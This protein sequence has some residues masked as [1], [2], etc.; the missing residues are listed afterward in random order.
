MQR[1]LLG[2]A[3]LLLRKP[4]LRAR[5]LHEIFGV[6]LIHDREIR[7]E[8]GRLSKAA[9]ETVRCG[10][11]GA[12]VHGAAGAAHEAFGAAEHFLGGP[13]REGQEKNP[14]GADSILEQVCDAIHER[15]RFSRARARDDQQR[16]VCVRSR[17]SFR[18]VEIRGEIGR[19]PGLDF[20]DA[21]RV[22]ARVVMHE[23]RI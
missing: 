11:K 14:L 6:G 19:A 5:E 22:D 13:P 18:R 15:A 4:E 9:E 10:V 20:A 23:I 12:A 3:L 7:R 17:L 2:K 21:G 8:T 16:P 1:G